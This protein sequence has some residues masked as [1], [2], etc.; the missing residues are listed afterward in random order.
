LAKELIRTGLATAGSYGHLSLRPALCPYLRG[1]LDTT[2][3]A[4][5]TA[6]WLLAMQGHIAFLVQ[7]QHKKT[8]LAAGTHPDPAGATEP[9]RPAGIGTKCRGCDGDHRANHWA[10]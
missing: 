8:E 7:Q 10:P 5:L 2:E 9:V 4:D 6:R 3:L 1:W